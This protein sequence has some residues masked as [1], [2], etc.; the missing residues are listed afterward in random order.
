[1][2]ALS[3]SSPVSLILPS[4]SLFLSLS[5][6]LF[7]YSTYPPQSLSFSPASLILPSL[8][9]SLSLISSSVIPPILPSFLSSIHAFSHSPQPLSFFLASSHHS[10]R[11][12]SLYHIYP[13][14][15]IWIKQHLSLP[16]SHTSRKHLHLPQPFLSLSPPQ[17]CQ[18]SALFTASFT[19]PHSPLSYHSTSRLAPSPFLTPTIIRIFVCTAKY[20]IRH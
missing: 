15:P 14:P 18:P 4:L 13:Y 8:S 11:H 7:S 12:S 2:L 6:I 10:T 19:S 20:E 1:M 9:L 17:D 5:H 3:S 16:L